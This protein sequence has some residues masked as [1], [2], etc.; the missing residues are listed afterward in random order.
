MLDPVAG[1]LEMPVTPAVRNTAGTLQGAMVALFAE[2]AAE[3]LV[4][5]R[6]GVPAVV[7]DLDLRYLAQTGEGPVRSECTLLGEG[8]DAPVQVELSDRSSGR[9]TTLV[10]ARTAVIGR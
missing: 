7:T 5:A 2:A 10:Y 6:F 9:L 8:P 1:A 3:E 4:S